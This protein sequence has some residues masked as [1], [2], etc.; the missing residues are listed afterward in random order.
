MDK[1]TE[2]L[3]TFNRIAWTSLWF[4]VI[5]TIFNEIHWGFQRSLSN[6]R[7]ELA[8]AQQLYNQS[9]AR[10]LLSRNPLDQA[11]QDYLQRHE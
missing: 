4:F 1:F 3:Q 11:A 5:I 10:I 2:F 8:K 9:Q 6:E 7:G